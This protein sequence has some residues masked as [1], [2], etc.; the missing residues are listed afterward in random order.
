MKLVNYSSA[1]NVPTITDHRMVLRSLKLNF[2]WNKASKA[3]KIIDLKR[4]KEPKIYWNFKRYLLQ[5]F[6]D[7]DVN[8]LVNPKNVDE[9]CVRQK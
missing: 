4:L 2:T 3:P 6:E 9:E 1:L 8:S 7:I 5:G